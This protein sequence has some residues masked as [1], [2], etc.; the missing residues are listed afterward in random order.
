[1]DICRDFFLICSFTWHDALL[2]FTSKQLALS[3]E[4]NR[5]L[6]HFHELSL[7]FVLEFRV[8]DGVEDGSERNLSDEFAYLDLEEPIP[9]GAEEPEWVAKKTQPSA[10]LRG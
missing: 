5:Y 3:Y 1:M 7:E 8:A 10:T 6:Y 4:K 2:N 9:G